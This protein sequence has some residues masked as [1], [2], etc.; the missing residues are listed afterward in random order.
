M[1]AFKAISGVHGAAR[2]EIHHGVGPNLRKGS[3]RD[4]TLEFS[5]LEA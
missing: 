2:H 3:V 5:I 4:K 1:V